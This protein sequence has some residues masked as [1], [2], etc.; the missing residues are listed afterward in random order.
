MGTDV[1]SKQQRM[2]AQKLGILD[3]IDSLIHDFLFK[4]FKDLKGGGAY[5]KALQTFEDAN[6]QEANR[7]QAVI[8]KLQRRGSNE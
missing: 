2:L 3:T 4:E 8:E 6:Q 7:I 5:R 1:K